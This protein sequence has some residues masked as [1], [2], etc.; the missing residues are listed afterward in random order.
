MSCLEMK[1]KIVNQ[2]K[3]N[4]QWTVKVKIT[5]IQRRNL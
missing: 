1:K 5:H 3:L 2:K 4:P